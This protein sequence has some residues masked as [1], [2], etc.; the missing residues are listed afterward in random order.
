MNSDG[1]DVVRLTYNLG[2]DEAAVWSPDGARIAF[3]GTQTGEGEIFTMDPDGSG[4]TQLTFAAGVDNDPDWSPDSASL[5]FW[6]NRGGDAEIYTMS[7]DG[8]GQ[9]NLTNSPGGDFQPAWSPDGT[10]VAF[11]S[12]RE[13][14]RQIWVMDADGGNQTRLTDNAAGDEDPDWQPLPGPAYDF[15][16]F[17]APVDNLPT[18]NFATAGRAVPVKFSLGGDRG[19][20]VF[21]AGFPSSRQIA[22]D[23]GATISEVEETASAGGSSLS[24]DA[25]TDTYT[26][27]WKT[28]KTW[29]GTC[30][31]LTIELADGTT[32]SADF[33]FR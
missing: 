10:K 16:G 6:S 13:G 4:Q 22:C 32:H 21:A 14:Y 7:P 12:N 9:V 23:V 15:V 27:V 20:L 18:V 33:R 3:A 26:Y 17:F 2:N 28:S 24:Y 19:L 25:A 8:A 31:Q 30:R 11:M 5:A 1:R 29:R